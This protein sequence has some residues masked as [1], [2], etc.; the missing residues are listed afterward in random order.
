[1]RMRRGKRQRRV[2]SDGGGGGG[3][4]SNQPAMKT[5]QTQRPRDL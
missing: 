2:D 5:S 3:C 1:M 4:R